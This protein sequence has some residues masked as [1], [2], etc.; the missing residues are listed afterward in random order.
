M[1]MLWP[2]NSDILILGWIYLYFS[3]CVDAFFLKKKST[4]VITLRPTLLPKEKWFL[5][6]FVFICFIS[7]SKWI[8]LMYYGP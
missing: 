7:Q 5:Y 3:F 6:V 8:G 1:N 4:I 2:W